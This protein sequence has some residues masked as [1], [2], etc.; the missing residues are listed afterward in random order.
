MTEEELIERSRILYNEGKY[1]EAKVYLNEALL[2]SQNVEEIKKSMLYLLL[3]DEAHIKAL[4]HYMLAQKR[5][6]KGELKA[7]IWNIKRCMK[8]VPNFHDSEV[9]LALY[10]MALGARE[11][12]ENSVWD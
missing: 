6:H 7:A 3:F 10:R 4:K 12:R 2:I 5:Y 11:Y 9:L 8:I 1:E